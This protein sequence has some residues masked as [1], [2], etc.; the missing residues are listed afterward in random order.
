MRKLIG[1]GAVL[2]AGCLQG[3]TGPAGAASFTVSGNFSNETVKDTAG[4]AGAAFLTTINIPVTSG[5]SGIRYQI[6]ETPIIIKCPTPVLLDGYTFAF[7]SNFI[8][9]DDANISDSMEADGWHI[10]K[11]ALPVPTDSAPLPPSCTYTL[12]FP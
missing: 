4:Y 10:Q 12:V 1:L 8:W 6:S 11:I 9:Q 7:T 3:P 5:I 2:L